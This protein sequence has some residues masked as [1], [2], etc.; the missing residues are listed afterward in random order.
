MRAHLHS[1]SSI[2]RLLFVFLLCGAQPSASLG[3]RGWICGWNLKGSANLAAQLRKRSV[4]DIKRQSFEAVCVQRCRNVVKALTPTIC[5]RAVITYAAS[6]LLLRRKAAYAS[7][8][9]SPGTT[10]SALPPAQGAMVWLALFTLSAGMHSA[11]SAITKISPW[12]VKEF[13]DEEVCIT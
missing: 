10:N 9:I 4:P 12:K 6:I 13:A 7:A 5:R 2:V 8:A 3:V 11:E 1:R